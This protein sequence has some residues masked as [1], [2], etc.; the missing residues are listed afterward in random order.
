MIR[1]FKG[2]LYFLF[3]F[4]IFILVTV[5]TIGGDLKYTKYALLL[6]LAIPAKKILQHIVFPFIR[7]R[8][9]A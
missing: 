3:G 5:G 8:L 2:L 7:K 4:L 9:F 1:L 6:L